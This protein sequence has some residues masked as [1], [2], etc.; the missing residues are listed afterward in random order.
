MHV[1]ELEKVHV[2]ELS[3]DGLGRRARRARRARL[4][5]KTGS[6]M[7]IEPTDG[8]RPTGEPMTD[9]RTESTKT[10]YDLHNH[11]FTLLGTFN[12]AME[13]EVEAAK[14][15]HQTGNATQ[16]TARGIIT[17]PVVKYSIE[18]WERDATNLL[19]GKTVSCVRYTTDEERDAYGWYEGAPIIVFTDGSEIMASGDDEGNRAGAL[20]T[21]SNEMPVIPQMYNRFD[22]ES[23]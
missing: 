15:Q 7:M 16:I 18:Y 5:K 22:S 2:R 6:G 3:E 11:N 12:T 1:S 9:K 23:K 17:E 19:A 10:T 21:S 14:Y 8:L 20:F 4:D 13:A